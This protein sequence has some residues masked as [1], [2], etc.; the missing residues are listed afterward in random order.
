ANT[1]RRTVTVPALL[2]SSDI[3]EQNMD[4]QYVVYSCGN[5]N[6]A[7]QT[8]VYSNSQLTR[9]AS[10]TAK[11]L[12]MSR[13]TL[14]CSLACTTFQVTRPG[15]EASLFGSA[16]IINSSTTAIMTAVASFGLAQPRANMG[17]RKSHRNTSSVKSTS[18]ATS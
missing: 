4:R 11:P 12:P 17:S 14:H 9:M 2:M 10:A 13:I 6:R 8:P 18:T 7:S 3:K 5:K 15:L 16:G 1:G